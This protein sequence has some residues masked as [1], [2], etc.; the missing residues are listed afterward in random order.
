MGVRVGIG[1]GNDKLF[2]ELIKPICVDWAR[3]DVAGDNP[4]DNED[5]K[6]WKVLPS[7]KKLALNTVPS[8]KGPAFALFWDAVIVSGLINKHE[9]VQVG[10]N[11]G[12]VVHK[13]C[14]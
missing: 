7:D 8:N 12:N 3:D 1:E 6:D 2:Q 5:R 9:H 14:L 4:I 13:C 11:I 10:D